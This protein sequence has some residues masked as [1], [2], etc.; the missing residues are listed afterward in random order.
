[1]IGTWASASSP[2]I[3]LDQLEPADVRQLD[4]GND[5]VGRETTGGFK[6]VAAVGHRLGL[7]AMGGEQIAEQLD[8][9]R[10]VLDDENLRQFVCL[11]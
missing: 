3:D 9:Q 8:V 7:M 6:R 1:M 10:I 2:R 4:V 11:S 5:Q